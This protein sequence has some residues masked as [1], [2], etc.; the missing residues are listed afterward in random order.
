MLN[1]GYCIPE[2]SNQ[3][4]SICWHF[5]VF[6]GIIGKYRRHWKYPYLPAFCQPWTKKQQHICQVFWNRLA[7]F[8]VS[9]IWASSVILMQFFKRSGMGW[10]IIKDHKIW[11]RGP[12][13]SYIA[14]LSKQVCILTVEDSAKFTALRFMYKFYRPAP[15]KHQAMFFFL[16]NT[17]WRLNLGRRSPKEHFCQVILKLVQWFLTK[18]FLKCFIYPYK[19]LPPNGHFFFDESWQLEQTW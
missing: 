18:R 17:S 13:W 15:T 19:A 6:A 10:M 16:L 3:S 1:V 9:T 14:H 8:T 4:T 12:W 2:G 11:T 7:S 5:P